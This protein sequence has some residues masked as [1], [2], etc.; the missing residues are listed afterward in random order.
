[1]GKAEWFLAHR[2]VVLLLS[3]FFWIVCLA[4]GLTCVV[5][6]LHCLKHEKFH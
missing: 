5:C 2:T 4:I 3:G 1:M 6:S